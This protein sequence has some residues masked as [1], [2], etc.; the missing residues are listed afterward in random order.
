[1]RPVFP[2][3]FQLLRQGGVTIWLS[4]GVADPQFADRLVTADRL[5][6]DAS[7][8]IIKDQRKIKIG[9]LTVQVSG[10]SRSIYVK[11]YNR[12]ALRYAISGLIFGSGALRSLRGATLLA[13]GAI[14]TVIPVAAV[15]ERTFGML[16][17][18]FFISEEIVG[19]RPARASWIALRERPGIA[20]I[21]YRRAFLRGLALLFQKLHGLRIYHNDLKEANILAAAVDET[22][23]IQ[24]FL[25][26][27]EGVRRCRWLSARRRIKNL[28]QIYR[29]LGPHLSRAQQLFF[30][31]TYLGPE[32]SQLRRKRRLI[33]VLRRRA[34]RVTEQKARHSRRNS[35]A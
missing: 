5:F 30:L 7:C 33:R 13:H 6:E 24:F 29:T 15:E 32:F 2:P 12:F 26:D 3:E 22:P 1:L 19:G 25:L 11:K 14:P 10:I 27:L 17:Q 28:V 23:E 21:H 16:R 18:S 9:R 35:Q 4:R 31:K 34:R 8:R 20:G